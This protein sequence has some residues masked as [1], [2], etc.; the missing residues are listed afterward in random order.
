MLYQAGAGQTQFIGIGVSGS[1]LT[2][3]GSV[4]TYQST[5]SLVVGFAQRSSTAT[6]IAGGTIGQLLYQAGSGDTAFV[7][8][9]NAG[10]VLVSRGSAI[11]AYQN[12]LTLAGTVNATSTLTGAFI[13]SGGVGIGR[14]LW[15]G[16]TGYFSGSQV[17][18]AANLGLFGVAQI[19]AGT[20]IGISPATGTG[21]V[22]VTNLGV[23]SLSTVTSG[24]L[25]I[26][27]STGSVTIQSI[28]TLQ[29]VTQRGATTNQ[30]ISITATNVSVS[31]S[32][33]QALL[34]SGGIG[35][36]VVRAS[37]LFDSG[38]RVITNVV[39]VAGTGISITNVSTSNANMTFQVNN[40]G[41][42]S[43]IGTT[44]LG[45][46]AGTGAVTFTNLGV[47]SLTAGSGLSVSTST[48]TITIQSIDTLQSVTD[49]GFTT[50]N[51]INVTNV[52]SATTTTNGAVTIAG[53]L[54]VAGDIYAR[55]I[56]T[57][58]QI[59]GGQTSTS[60]NL[61]GG[62]TGDI[63][64]QI[65]PGLT[66]FIGIGPSGSILFSNGTT[67]TWTASSA[68]VS[69]IALTATN[70]AGGFAGWIPIQR[71]NS[72]TSFITSGTNGQLLQ[73][74][75]NTATWVSTSSLFVN[76]SI[77]AVTAT[78]IA[79][80]TAGQL[81]YQSAVGV[82]DF[83]PLGNAG[84]ILTSNG[85][86]PPFFSNTL[87]LNS[88]I[89]ATSTASGALQVRG[90]AGIGGNLWVGGV[91]YATVQGSINTATNIALGTAG[92][93]PYQESPGVTRFIGIG[94][95][96]SVL[97]SN[98]STATYLSTTSLTV[99]Y[100]DTTR[101][102]N[103]ITGGVQ[104]S[105]PYQDAANTTRFIGIGAV[106]SVLRSNGTTA[107]WIT[108]SSLLVGEAFLAS[109]A[110]N[111]AAGL[112]GSIPYQTTAGRTAFIGIGAAGTILQSDGTT[113][114]WFSTGS[115][116]TGVA[117]N[118]NGGTRGAI[119][120]QDTTSTTRFIAPGVTGSL[121]QMQASGTAT[122]IS[123]SSITVDRATFAFTATLAGEIAGAPAGGGEL[124]YQAGVNDTRFLSTGT[125]GMILV[126]RPGLPQYENT[127]TL[128]GNVQ[129]TS[130]TTGALV[131][132]GGVGIG[133]NLHVGGTLFAT[134][135]GS[136]NTATNIA[137]GAA[138][139]LV[140]QSA[141]GVTTFVGIGV[142]GTLLA[143]NGSIPAYVS[144]T[145]LLVGD[146]LR[147]QSVNNITGGA[148]GS[149]P[150][151]TGPNA[152]SFIGIGQAGFLLQS[153]GTTATWVS[154]GSLVTGE[155]LNAR[156]ISGGAA[157][158]IP[159]QSATS[160]TTFSSNFT[161]N[162]TT[163]AIGSGAVQ[164]FSFLPTSATVPTNG[165]YLPAT[166]SIGLASNST[167]RMI[168]SAAGLIG[169]GSTITPTSL[170]HV[171]GTVNIAGITTVTNT[172]AASSTITGAFQVA[173][174]VGIGGRVFIG[175]TTNAISTV[176]GAM[177]VNGGASFNG[178][179]WARNVYA[180]SLDLAAYTA[181]MAT[182]FG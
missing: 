45:V 103:N 8:V 168:I 138:G 110:T 156:N 25:A 40:V 58:G 139:S 51:R 121:L 41:V 180:D 13:V 159:Y 88:S 24:G 98:G 74:G 116:L 117:Q 55:N 87:T 38:N 76:N 162:G 105:I 175:D 68:L 118:I 84:E 16:G 135:Q 119:P 154:T 165:L 148:T 50:T 171:D 146:A 72:S 151:Q 89:Q 136:I 101:S 4:P 147:S 164:A 53:G 130:T 36:L 86:S 161:Y 64:Y 67:A 109:T 142:A 9:G 182:A 49:R 172:T 47:Q 66:G 14:D 69:G 126:S 82:T 133:G 3:N 63:V 77:F 150:Y 111:I 28:E 1:V 102:S 104:G 83:V 145:T 57:N 137:G 5:Q 35:A 113:A 152:T 39:P 163:L 70:V 129:A 60:T 108:T 107:T 23:Q 71:A 73:M 81:H 65:A 127:L 153:N 15:V 34:V 179:I 131:V 30:P 174:G 112:T 140:Y 17:V 176:S 37:N 78:N 128:A 22:T 144:T 85:S 114:T 44:F 79:G 52:T 21:T 48:G 158:Q 170:L 75:I 100:A 10:E 26:S 27:T 157:N 125:E 99:G 96:G 124:H 61:A 46:S 173:G 95:N 59:V 167:R 11:P 31:T 7:G 42:T 181:I 122:F 92:A 2:S 12:T 29:L 80:G 155:A 120:Y 94:P 149:I 166:N 97:F 178:D 141:A 6:D 93:I 134:V 177:V 91:L 123:T 132:R 32:T 62:N 143:S 115:L 160:V 33:G 18:T 54:G 20:A 19:V 169:V 43:A 56:Y 106:G 90:G